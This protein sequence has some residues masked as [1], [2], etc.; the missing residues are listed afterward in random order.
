MKI[1]RIKK[2]GVSQ[3]IRH[4]TWYLRTKNSSKVLG[5]RPKILKRPWFS[6]QCESSRQ[7]IQKIMF[8]QLIHMCTCLV[9]NR[10]FKDDVSAVRN[11][12][13]KQW[14]TLRSIGFIVRHGF[15]Y[16]T[17]VQMSIDWVAN[18]AFWAERKFQIK[19]LET[20]AR[21]GQEGGAQL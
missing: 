6:S 20:M 14:V 1:E 9:L 15:I 4:V 18:G 16:L 11:A 2:N 3:Q 21:D 19:V 12:P 5:S 7:S 8:S 13:W 17:Q 10:Y